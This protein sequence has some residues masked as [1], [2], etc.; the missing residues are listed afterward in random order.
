MKTF[1]FNVGLTTNKQ[2]VLKRFLTE[3]FTE[4]YFRYHLNPIKEYKSKLIIGGSE[5]C[6]Y[7]SFESPAHFSDIADIVIN[8]ADMLEQDCIAMV[9]GNNG[10]LV[11]GLNF[12]NNWGQFNPTYFRR[13]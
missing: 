3:N 4:W 13:P 11:H 9:S 8:L 7:I 10:E 5:D 2:R 12:L 6:I 1:E